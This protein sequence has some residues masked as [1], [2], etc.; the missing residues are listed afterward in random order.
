MREIEH[1]ADETT[2]EIVRRVNST[3]VTPF[4]DIY[5]LASALD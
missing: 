5:R 4:E 2:H 1:V 3:F